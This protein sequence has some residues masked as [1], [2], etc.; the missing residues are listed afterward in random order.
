MMKGMKKAMFQCDE[1]MEHV[2]ETTNGCMP[3]E[4]VL[5]RR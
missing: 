2:Y 4:N 3:Q 5:K 1:M